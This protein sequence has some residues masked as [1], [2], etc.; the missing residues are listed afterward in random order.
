MLSG[1]ADK[2]VVETTAP[3][4]GP[5]FLA[6]KHGHLSARKCCFSAA[7]L[8]AVL[9]LLLLVF[10]VVGAYLPTTETAHLTIFPLFSQLQKHLCWETKGPGFRVSAMTEATGSVA[11]LRRRS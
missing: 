11:E 6:D 4:H 8:N 2:L 9:L 1:E 3:P 7:S 10:S 5:R